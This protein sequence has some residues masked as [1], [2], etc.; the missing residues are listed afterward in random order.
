MKRNPYYTH[1]R[2]FVGSVHYN[3]DEEVS[4]CMKVS[5]C[6]LYKQV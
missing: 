5:L 6:S 2:T 1:R 3:S 4:K